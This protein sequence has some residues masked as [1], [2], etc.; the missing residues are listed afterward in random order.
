MADTK[1][2]TADRVPPAGDMNDNAAQLMAAL[3]CT[4]FVAVGFT[5]GQ[6]TI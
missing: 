4:V 5:H 6:P 1:A 2:R 3:I